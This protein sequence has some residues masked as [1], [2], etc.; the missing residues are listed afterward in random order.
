MSVASKNIRSRPFL[1]TRKTAGHIVIIQE[2]SVWLVR[3]VIPVQRSVI[4]F[5]FF[6]FFSH[7]PPKT[8]RIVRFSPD[9]LYFFLG[10]SVSRFFTSELSIFSCRAPFSF[11]S[12]IFLCDQTV[13]TFHFPFAL[14]LSLSLFSSPSCPPAQVNC[15]SR[16]D[17]QKTH[18]FRDA[19]KQISLLCCETHLHA[20]F[21]W[22]IQNP[23]TVTTCG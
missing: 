11:P 2:A 16:A 3:L 9:F 19:P 14:P 8:K 6:L 1:R 23:S 17:R 20:R 10:F 4:Y 5:F 12:P 15:L 13:L 22:W 21:P 7:L 18:A